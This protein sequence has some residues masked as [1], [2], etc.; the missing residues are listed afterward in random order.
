[1]A[2]STKPYIGTRDF[3]PDDMDFRNWMF[4]VQRKV[5]ESFGYREFASPIVEPLDLYRA[6]SSDEIVGEQMYNFMDRGE[7]EV[8]IR[9]ELTPSL[10]RMAAARLQQTPQP[11]RWFNIG[12]FMRYE[13]PGR[14]RL[15]EFWQLNVDLLGSAGEAADV[16]ILQMAIEILRCYGA[17]G[18]HFEMRFSDRRLLESLLGGLPAEQMRTISR[19][20]DKRARIKPEEFEASLQEA[21]QNDTGIIKNVN[22]LLELKAEDLPALAEEGRLDS[23]A[24]ASLY[25]IQ[26]RLDR[27]GYG[28]CIHFDP[29]IVRGF[30]YYTGL[31]FEINDRHPEN[32]RALFGGGRYD[33]L[34]G[35]FTKQSVPAIGF[36]MGDVTL[37]NF[38]RSH[39]L[40][41]LDLERRQGIF[42]TLMDPDFSLECQE[43]ALELR[44]QGLLVE[45]ALEA[46]RKIGKQF[47]LADKKGRRFALVLGSDEIENKT[48]RVKDLASG[49]QQDCS[50]A[51]LIQAMT[52][53]Q[54]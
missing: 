5:C 25:H 53:M 7:R 29:T 19:L 28:D 30:D 26:G 3:Y 46:S 11:M 12:N 52:D 49:E 50:R 6:K 2:L 31:V 54:N 41:P 23:L 44:N 27:L 21:T 34:I 43:L 38:I 39:N 48:V 18:A 42:I 1:M 9:P 35:L 16:E 13:R 40:G 45:I 24:A 22:T 37:E 32:N 51:K 10:A 47:E 8:A 15:R 14:G 17:T 20:L 36:G 4:A 33:N